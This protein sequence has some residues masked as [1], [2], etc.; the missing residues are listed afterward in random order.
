L[1]KNLREARD[2]LKQA[3]WEI[4][5]GE[6]VNKENQPL[7]FNV[8]LAQKGMD[9]ILAP[10]ARN[11]AKLGI[12]MKYRTVDRSLYIRRIREFDYDMIVGSYPESMSPGNELRNM[13]HSVSADKK[14]SRN[15]IGIKD[16]VVDMLVD[17]IIMSKNREDL[18]IAC[19]ALDRVLLNGNY[20]VPNWYINTHRIA[21]WD[22]FNRPKKTPLYYNPKEWMIA[23]WWLK[24]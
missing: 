1:R 20:L 4:K 5:S 22:K 15:Y 10:F 6:L 18:I 12:V 14:G 3:G 9:R 7:K 13:F 8:L 19:H 16:P 23:S 11:L 17:S 21:Y 24:D 2:I